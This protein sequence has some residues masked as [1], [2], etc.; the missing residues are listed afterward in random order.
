MV[1]FIYHVQSTSHTLSLL[2]LISNIALA[3]SNLFIWC[4]KQPNWNYQLLN[5]EWR[6]IT[7]FIDSCLWIVVVVVIIIIIILEVVY[8]NNDDNNNNNNNNK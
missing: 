7:F 2:L 1:G 4:L 8:S 6:A 5:Y 3:H